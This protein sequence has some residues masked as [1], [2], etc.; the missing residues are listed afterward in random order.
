MAAPGRAEAFKMT[1]VAGIRELQA[2]G[3]PALDRHWV[4]TLDITD[5]TPEDAAEQILTHTKST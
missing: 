2:G 3:T 4:L 5:V 1:S